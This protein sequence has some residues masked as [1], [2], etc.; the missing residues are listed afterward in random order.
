MSRRPERAPA[1]LSFD[2]KKI[3]DQRR[4]RKGKNRTEEKFV[5]KV[6]KNI[7][8]FHHKEAFVDH[9]TSLQLRRGGKRWLG[10][11]GRILLVK[12][13][14]VKDKGLLRE[15]KLWTTCAEALWGKGEVE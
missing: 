14:V 5:L 7:R 10:G 4:K 12:I 6:Q 1:A 8:T 3:R 2:Q 11:E 9:P 13:T 15:Q